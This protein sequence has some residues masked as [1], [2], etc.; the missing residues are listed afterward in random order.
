MTTSAGKK[1]L[2]LP[3]EWPWEETFTTVLAA[4]RSIPKPS[5]CPRT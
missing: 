3:T 5:I 4:L 1:T 2:H